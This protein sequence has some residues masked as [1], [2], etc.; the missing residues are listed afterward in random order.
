M[1]AD[2]AAWE[3]GGERGRSIHLFRP[4]FPWKASVPDRREAPIGRRGPEDRPN[5]DAVPR[6]VDGAMMRA[7]EEA[8]P[9][10]FPSSLGGKELGAVPAISWI[11]RQ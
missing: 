1:E 6:A 9:A 10:L 7:G 11:D 8:S 3:C 4:G 2:G 5:G